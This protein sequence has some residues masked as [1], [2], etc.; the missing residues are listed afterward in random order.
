M[1]D[2]SIHSKFMILYF[3][4]LHSYQCFL[5]IICSLIRSKINNHLQATFIEV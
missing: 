5:T 1:M 4:L 3:D 2:D